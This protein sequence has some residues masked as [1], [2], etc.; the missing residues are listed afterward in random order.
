MHTID[1]FFLSRV[2]LQSANS[3]HKR[4]T[5]ASSDTSLFKLLNNSHEISCD[6]TYCRDNPEKEQGSEKERKEVK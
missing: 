3:L 1:F 2:L 6:F 5:V 4:N